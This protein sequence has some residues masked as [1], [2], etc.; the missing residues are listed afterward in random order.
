[1]ADYFLV[2]WDIVRFAREQ[3]IRHT[4]RGSAADLA[5]VYCLYIT[6]VDAIGREL[7]FER[8]LSLERAQQ[9]DIDVDF[10]AR[11]RDDISRYRWRR[12]A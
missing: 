4:G 3:G 2:A 10:D 7:L 12:K 5:V 8:F 11:Y 1:M 9:P 6:N